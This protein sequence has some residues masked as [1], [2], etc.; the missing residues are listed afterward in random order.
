[1][2]IGHQMLSFACILPGS[3]FENRM[4]VQSHLHSRF[5]KSKKPKN[6]KKSAFL[7]YFLGI[8]LSLFPGMPFE[9]PQKRSKTGLPGIKCCQ[10]LVFSPVFSLEIECES[11]IAVKVVSQRQKTRKKSKYHCFFFQFSVF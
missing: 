8:N 4:R 9:K 11:K 10:S 2:S 1:M 7:A 6:S 3:R 5:R